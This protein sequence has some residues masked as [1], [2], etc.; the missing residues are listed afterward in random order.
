MR[1]L[2]RPGVWAL[3]ALLAL[4]GTAYGAS[5]VL[6]TSSSQVKAGSLAA[7]DLSRSARTT[8]K[9]SRGPAGPAGANGAPGLPGY[10]GTRDALE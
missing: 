5:K 2:L 10:K 7:S 8:L 4:A 3:L 1:H 6:I 9:G